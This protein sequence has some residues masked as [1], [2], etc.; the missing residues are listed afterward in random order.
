MRRGL[1]VVAALILADLVGAAAA[2]TG[3]GQPGEWDKILEAARK[4]GKVVVSIPPSRKLRRGMEVA[5][6]RR[7]GIGVEFVSARSS[8]SI[9]KIISEAKAG[10]QYVDLHVGGTESAVTGLLA[11]KA[12][13]PVEPYFVLPQVKEPKQWWGGHMWMDNAK[14]FIYPF[15]AYQSVRLWCNPN[16][17]KPAEFQSFDDLLNPKLRGKIGISDPRT[18]G[19]GNS[20]WSHMLSVKGEEYL[21]SLVAQ[22]LFVARDLRLLGENLGSGKIAVALGIGHSELLPFIKTGL[23]VAPLPYPKEGLHT[24][25]GNGNLMVIKNPPHPNA[26]KVF[27]N[28]LLGRDGQEI[29]GRSMAVGSRRLDVD[30]K[31]LKEFGV[32]ASKDSLTVEHFYLLENQSEEKVYK[33]REPGAAAARK[34]LGS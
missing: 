32:I 2:Q 25:V 34:L 17:Y 4:E 9:Q 28:W 31:W 33:L 24:T 29:F 1:L 23:P 10:I 8:A 27:A 12:L 22:R 18:P 26:A 14:R 30:T 6:T 13:E 20:M 5:F 7:Y 21:K 19:S 11:E 16:E 15:A 3:Q